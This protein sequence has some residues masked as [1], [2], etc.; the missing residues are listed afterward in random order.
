MDQEQ[1]RARVKE[2]ELALR[3][4]EVRT[5]DVRRELQAARNDAARWTP[6]TVCEMA[7]QVGGVREWHPVRIE[8]T[9]L[10]GHGF[11][12]RRMKKNGD[13]YLSEQWVSETKLRAKGGE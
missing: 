11:R 7:V 13:W 10:T 6:G 9:G 1:A 4:L 5:N 2:L 3:Q 8:G 12:V